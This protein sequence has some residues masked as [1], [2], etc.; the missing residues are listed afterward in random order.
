MSDEEVFVAF[1]VAIAAFYG[2]FIYALFR[3]FGG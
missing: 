3:T 2:L 1:L